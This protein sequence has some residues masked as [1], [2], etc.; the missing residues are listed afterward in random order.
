M[1]K[2]IGN[3]FGSIVPISPGTPA[4]SAVYNLYDQ[5]YS[6]RDGGWVVFDATGGSKTTSGNYTIH[7]FTS[8][9]SLVVAG[10]SRDLEY[11]VI[12]GGGAG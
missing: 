1:P 4:P 10:G 3:R 8:S 5:Y 9:G 11:L 6:S 12:A 7:T 2:F